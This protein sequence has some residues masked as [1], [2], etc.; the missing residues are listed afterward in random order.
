M[1]RYLTA[2]KICLLLLAEIYLAD[3]IPSK[4]KLDLLAFIASQ[5][6]PS[7]VDQDECDLELSTSTLFLTRDI[8]AFAEKL[9]PCQSAVPGRSLYDIFLQRLWTLD[10]LDSLY[11]LFEQLNRLVATPPS[12]GET[13]TVGK[14]S[15]ASPLGLYIRRCSVEFTRLQ[16]ADAQSLWVELNRYRASSFPTWAERNPESVRERQR[17]LDI[18]DHVASDATAGAVEGADHIGRVFASTDD[19]SK[20]LNLSINHLQNTGGRVPPTVRSRLKEWFELQA[21]APDDSSTSAATLPK[22]ASNEPLQHFL[23]FF[24]HWRAGQYTSALESLHR[25]FDY[26]LIDERTE[27]AAPT[28]GLKTYYQYALLHLSVLHSDFECWA[29]AVEALEECIAIG[30]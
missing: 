13:G 22:A 7:S 23:A 5:T 8:S 21:E 10:G 3:A 6:T 16:F 26:S 30:K 29:E 24:E 18:I 9:G 27:T 19:V 11:F 4:D 1:P 20:L 17:R 12:S 28:S 2:P 25:Y 14:V 15:R